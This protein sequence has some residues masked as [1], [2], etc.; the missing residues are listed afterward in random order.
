MSAQ[1]MNLEG[2]V[3]LDFD[4]QANVWTEVRCA[5]GTVLKI[6]LV[7]RS[8]KRL[9]QYEPDGSPVYIVNS[10]N[11]IRAIIPKELLKK[12]QENPLPS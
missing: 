12:Q 1:Q 6:K 5:D 8:V 11:V 4:E 2:S 7:V 10:M 3:D 9:Q